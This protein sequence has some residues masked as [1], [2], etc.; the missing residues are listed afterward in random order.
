MY[1]FL[2][3]DK[4]QNEEKLD[5]HSFPWI[6]ISVGSVYADIPLYLCWSG[7]WN[8][9]FVVPTCNTPCFK[10]AKIGRPLAVAMNFTFDY[11]K[12]AKQ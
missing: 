9:V 12:P 10:L 2:L 5:F 7:I 3:H 11:A 6:Y 8:L 1:L 4:A